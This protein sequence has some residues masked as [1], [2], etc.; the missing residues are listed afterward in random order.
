MDGVFILQFKE[1]ESVEEFNEVTSNGTVVIDF[2]ATWC[3][4]CKMLARNVL[5]IVNEAA[6]VYGVDIEKLEELTKDKGVMGV[7][8]VLIFKDG[9]EVS[10]SNGFKP[11]EHFLDE[12]KSK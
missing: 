11:A 4:P 10:R 2:F 6:P 7:P 12:I 9:V 5:P 8:T 3:N 1:I